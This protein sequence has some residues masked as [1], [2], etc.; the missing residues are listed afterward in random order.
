MK[1]KNIGQL[2]TGLLLIVNI[3]NGQKLPGIQKQSIYASIDIRGKGEPLYQAYNKNTQTYYTMAND[4]KN[5][6][7]VIAGDKSNIIGKM[8]GGGIT[9]TVKDMSG[10]KPSRPLSTKYPL[11]Q[12]SVRYAIGGLFSDS[13]QTTADINKTLEAESR[14]I[15]ITGMKNDVPDT[16][17]IYNDYGITAM[18]VLGVKRWYVCEVIVPLKYLDELTDKDPKLSFNIALNPIQSYNQ[19]SAAKQA[20]FNQI[21]A[22]GN[23]SPSFL[24]NLSI[25]DFSGEYVLASKP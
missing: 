19:V 13:S 10:K 17:S 22:N 14:E 20:A 15:L 18:G 3:A 16:V 2:A 7:I 5:L 9:F 23:L 4:D 11:F 8:I 24:S 6:Y 21:I 25:T 12:R 1:L